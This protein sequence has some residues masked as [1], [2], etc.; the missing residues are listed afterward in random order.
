MP[1]D[2]AYPGQ[3]SPSSSSPVERFQSSERHMRDE[4]DGSSGPLLGS[5]ANREDD[6]VLKNA[7][8]KLSASFFLLGLL[9]CAWT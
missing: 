8:R 3:A 9:K 1:T 7:L 6:L 2:H 4:R 5:I